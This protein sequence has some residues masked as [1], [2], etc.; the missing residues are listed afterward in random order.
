[1]VSTNITALL[2]TY[3]NALHILHYHGVL[4]G[5]GH[6]SVR[7]PN[8]PPTFFIMH[9][10]APALV[11][12]L[13]DIGEYRVS[14][15]T[16]V[17]PGTEDAPLEVYI[18]SEILKRY[19]DVNVVLHGHPDELISYGISDVPLKTVIHMAPFLG[20]KVPVFDIT[21]YYR[22]NDTQ[23]FLVRNQR[24]GAALA[25]EF[26]SPASCGPGNGTQDR[27][28]NYHDKQ[29]D[30]Y[31][32]DRDYC[33]DEDHGGDHRTDQ[34]DDHD[35]NHHSYPHHNLVLMQSHGFT[36]VATTIEI[37]TYEGIYAVTN[38]KVQSGAL[39]IQH[40]YTGKAARGGNGI[41]YLNQRQI[42]DSWATEIEVAER[43]WDLWVREVK[44]D[45]LYVNELDP[46]KY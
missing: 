39:N 5:F 4:D 2:A 16:P 43:T 23:D 8:N 7:N 25:A 45:P 34:N 36:A 37:A 26:D 42:R 19:P 29:H 40:A 38:A 21:K 24:L 35:R 13:D 46:G 20:K 11:S 15:A 6:L 33:D 27:N 41:A 14:D 3:I 31:N 18:H 22:P 30:D 9:S 10:M 32:G 17:D 12:G 44:V 28:G 1:M